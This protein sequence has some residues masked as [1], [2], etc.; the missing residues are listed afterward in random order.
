LRRIALATAVVTWAAPSLAEPPPDGGAAPLIGPS[1]AATSTVD[2]RDEA[3][4]PP[5]PDPSRPPPQTPGFRAWTLPEGWP[6][7][8]PPGV[9]SMPPGYMDGPGLWP[10]K[11]EV[12][13]ARLPPPLG[14]RLSTEPRRN[15]WVAGLATLASSY[16]VA[17][18]F[19][20]AYMTSDD[21]DAV[22]RGATLFIPLLGPAIFAAAVE[23][24][25]TP[26]GRAGFAI[27]ALGSAAEGVGFGLLLAGFVF[28]RPV[29][30]R[31][32]VDGPPSPKVSIAPAPGGLGV[33]A[34]W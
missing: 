15:L 13:D 1:P 10:R 9:A 3:S 16:G 11:L 32:D 2:A 27:G 12:D 14:Y 23:P 19:G 22:G 6:T 29:Y 7:L 18:I 17:A 34:T 20:G 8:L 5:M 21:E 4:L 30:L 31:N 33:S 24:I 28:P 26:D 25:T